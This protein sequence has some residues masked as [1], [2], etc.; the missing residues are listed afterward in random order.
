M[1]VNPALPNESHT[2]IILHRSIVSVVAILFVGLGIWLMLMPR[3]VEDLYPMT[4]D[5]PMGVSEIRAVFGGL[6]L[7]VG[8]AVLWLVW[9]VRRA[10]D[11][12]A[13]MLFVF[14]AL[15]LARIVGLASEGIPYGPVL[16]ETIFE[17]AVFVI[18][19]ITTLVVR[20][21]E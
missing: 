11:G 8:G 13:V 12:G 6:M 20:N 1:I 17:T 2:M 18:V 14:G 21:R 10:M 4:L 5:G 16:N 9:R 7:G 19:L 15:L 3:A